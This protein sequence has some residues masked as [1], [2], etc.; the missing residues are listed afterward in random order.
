MAADEF[1]S[2]LVEEFTATVE[3]NLRAGDLAELVD[4]VAD[5]RLD[6]YTATEE[7]LARPDL[8]KPARD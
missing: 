3:R 2:L 7:I 8:F 5:G 6:P 4:Q 1:R